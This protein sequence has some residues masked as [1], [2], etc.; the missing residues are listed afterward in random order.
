MQV[1]PKFYQRQYCRPDV[2][3]TLAQ[4]SLSCQT[5]HSSSPKEH[6]TKDFPSQFKLNGTF[7]IST[8]FPCVTSMLLC[9]ALTLRGLISMTGFTVKWIVH[10][11]RI[12]RKSHPFSSFHKHWYTLCLDGYAYESRLDWLCVSALY[13]YVECIVIYQFH[14]GLLSQNTHL[15]NKI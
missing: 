14:K 1:G 4:P 15:L 11:I 5:C 7:V 8:T 2:G 12:R 6:L 3:P 10:R 13:W 9:H